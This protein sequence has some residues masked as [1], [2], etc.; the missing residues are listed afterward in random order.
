MTIKRGYI[1]YFMIIYN[2]KLKYDKTYKFYPLIP[3]SPDFFRFPG[4]PDIKPGILY[5]FQLFSAL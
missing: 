3:D 2:D 1:T 4:F 5:T